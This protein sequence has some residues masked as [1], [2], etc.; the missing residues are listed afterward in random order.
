VIGALGILL[1]TV[2]AGAEEKDHGI[3]NAKHPEP[4]VLFGGQP[5]EE[6]L[7]ALAAD[8]LSVV[9]DLRSENEDR[10]FDE[11]AALQGLGVSYVSLPADAGCD[12][13]D[14]CSRA[15]ALPVGVAS[16]IRCGAA[17]PCSTSR[18]IRRTARWGLPAPGPPVLG[19]SAGE[20]GAGEASEAA[21]PVQAT[22]QSPIE[23]RPKRR[24]AAARKE[25]CQLSAF[26][27]GETA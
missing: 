16:A 10:G 14:S 26:N 20:A 17:S 18:A 27:A 15:A 22:P 2:A 8:G 24:T 23:M 5:T 4:G 3:R 21:Q 7:Q 12:A 11:P 9:L 25:R 6:Q 13:T 19:E 1:A